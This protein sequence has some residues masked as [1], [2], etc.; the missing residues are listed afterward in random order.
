MGRHNQ[1]NELGF[2]GK[3]EGMKNKVKW[4]IKLIAIEFT[5]QLIYLD[6]KLNMHVL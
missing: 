2:L 3:L 6:P 4:I 5:I 1:L